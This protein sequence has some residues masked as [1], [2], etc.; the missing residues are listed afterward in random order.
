[1]RTI[2]DARQGSQA[3]QHRLRALAVELVQQVQQLVRR[4]VIR[5]LHQRLHDRGHQRLVD[6]LLRLRSGAEVRQRTL[7]VVD[8][9][10]YAECLF[11]LPSIME[12]HNAVAG[13]V[14]AF[15]RSLP[16]QLG[17]LPGQLPA[18]VQA[19]GLGDADVRE[20]SRLAQVVV[21]KAPRIPLSVQRMALFAVEGVFVLTSI[22]TTLL[23][24]SKKGVAS[25]KTPVSTYQ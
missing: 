10:I 6:E 16:G 17:P 22:T 4:A 19:L 15:R 25:C 18:S 7:P 1:M 13:A 11:L 23:E 20:V 24:K 14:H 5:P 2:D 3:R 9:S 12:P 21:P 8:D